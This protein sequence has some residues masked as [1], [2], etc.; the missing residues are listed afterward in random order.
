MPRPPKWLRAGVMAV[1]VASSAAALVACGAST[2]PTASTSATHRLA[3]CRSQWKDVGDSV[4]GMDQDTNPSALADRWTSVIATVAYYRSSGSVKDCRARVDGQIKAVT[5]LRQF[6][7]Q[8]RPYDMTY[9]LG[10]VEAAIDLYLHDPLPAPVRDDSGRKVEPPTKDAVSAAMKTLTDNAA[11]ANAELEPGWQETSSVDLTDV[12]ALT[13]T[14]QDLDFLAQDSPHWR[15]CE[16]ALQVLVAAI[17]AQEGLS[18]SGSTTGSTTPSA[19]P[20]ASPTS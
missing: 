8:L 9:Q 18:G 20:S 5:A 12:S 19:A 1:L 7:Q 6:S 2:S 4:L 11:Q 13:K 15:A 16:E 3:D 17:R 10:Q 14:M